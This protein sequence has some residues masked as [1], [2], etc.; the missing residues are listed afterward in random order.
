MFLNYLEALSWGASS[1]EDFVKHKR[2][3]DVSKRFENV[4]FNDYFN[5]QNQYK[6]WLRANKNIVLNITINLL[7]SHFYERNEVIN[8][9]DLTEIMKDGGGDLFE[10]Y[11]TFIEKRILGKKFNHFYFGYFN[12]RS[13]IGKFEIDIESENLLLFSTKNIRWY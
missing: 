11:G 2:V 9:E 4:S 6:N 1:E 10:Q 12:P 5:Y 8:R 13:V 3:R 7:V